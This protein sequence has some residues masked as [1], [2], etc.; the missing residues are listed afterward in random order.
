MSDNEKLRALL[1]E[2]V[3]TCGACGRHDQ[4]HDPCDCAG[5]GK[6]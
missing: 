6:K 2:P 1:A 4:P 5:E 3:A